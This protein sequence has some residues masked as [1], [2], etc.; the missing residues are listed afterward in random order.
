[1]PDSAEFLRRFSEMLP[2]PETVRLLVV[3]DEEEMPG[4]IGDYFEERR[5]LRKNRIS[6]SRTSRCR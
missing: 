3:D 5:A 2:T 1:M 4:R 6:L